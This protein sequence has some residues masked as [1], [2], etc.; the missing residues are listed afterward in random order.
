[1]DGQ[2]AGILNKIPA[3]CLAA[4]KDY[5]R[6]ILTEEDMS[7]EIAA[8]ADANLESLDSTKKFQQSWKE[9]DCEKST[10]FSNE[11]A[12][13]IMFFLVMKNNCLSHH[14]TNVPQSILDKLLLSSRE[15]D[16]A[17]KRY[18]V[19]ITFCNDI[20]SDVNKPQENK[21]SDPTQSGTS[22]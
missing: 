20:T 19:L 22:L 5:E 6:S 11:E 1:L 13:D 12:A 18:W 21:A 17:A 10:P 16:K 3:I 15:G 14:I 7:Q 8:F 9:N 2:S 4:V